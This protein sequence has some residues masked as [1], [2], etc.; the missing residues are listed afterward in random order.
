MHRTYVRLPAHFYRVSLHTDTD[1]MTIALVP[2][3]EHANMIAHLL[4]EHYGLRKGE[5]IRV[6]P[7]VVRLEE[8]Q[9]DLL[10]PATP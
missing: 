2:D 4:Q 10:P 8:E 9:F 5:S 7:T 1:S 6:T 3:E